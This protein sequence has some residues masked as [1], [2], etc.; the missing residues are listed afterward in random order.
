MGATF[1]FD[2]EVFNLPDLDEISY[3]FSHYS[4]VADLDSVS[5]PSNLATNAT[6]SYD[7]AQQSTGQIAYMYISMVEREGLIVNNRGYANL[8]TFH[9][10]SYSDN[11]L[12]LAYVDLYLTINYLSSEGDTVTIPLEE[13]TVD[14]DAEVKLLRRTW[15]I[16]FGDYATDVGYDIIET[17]DGGFVIAGRYTPGEVSDA[18]LMKIDSLG[19]YK[20]GRTFTY[21]NSGENSFNAIAPTSDGGFIMTGSV[22]NNGDT[23]SYDVYLAKADASGILIWDTVFGESYPTE[24][25]YDVIQASDGGYVL[26]A[27][28]EDSL[29]LIKT[30]ANGVPVW[31]TAYKDTVTAR[32]GYYPYGLVQTPDGGYLVAGELIWYSEESGNAFLLKA[33]ANGNVTWD[34]EYESETRS[35]FQGYYHGYHQ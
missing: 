21:P 28:K 12:E 29:L 2:V 4:R 17:S 9:F 3:E 6:F 11:I 7:I 16:E 30:N 15:E 5:R 1:S 18:Y 26:C 27:E 13:V 8:G 22:Y 23:S 35:D 10:S 31:Q 25:A 34:R 14:D 19:L 32:H 20:W 33:D 24:R